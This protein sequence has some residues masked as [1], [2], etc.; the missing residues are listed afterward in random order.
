MKKVAKSV[1][2]PVWYITQEDGPG[3]NLDIDDRLELICTV[4]HTEV[5]MT[6]P[7]GWSRPLNAVLEALYDSWR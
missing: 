4:P 6:R 2:C 7:I 1:G 3:W 5:G